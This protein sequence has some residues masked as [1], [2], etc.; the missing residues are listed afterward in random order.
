MRQK[1]NQKG[2]SLVELLIVVAVIGIIAAIAIPN[3]TASRRAANEAS[4]IQSLRSISSAQASYYNT[5]ANSYGSFDTLRNVSLL[6]PSLSNA[7]TA[8]SARSGYIFA[9]NIPSSSSYVLG[10][11][12]VDVKDGSR[13]FTSDATG[14]IYSSAATPGSVPT[15]TS[16]SPIGN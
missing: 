5:G 13:N 14:V 16:G 6:D 12:P 11:A 7:T 15:S 1:H 4:A 9:I 10:A 8:S 2:F 3:L